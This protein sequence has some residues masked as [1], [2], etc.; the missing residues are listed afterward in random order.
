MQHEA[1]YLMDFGRVYVGSYFYPCLRVPR[2][3]FLTKVAIC[4]ILGV[5]MWGGISTP[6]RVRINEC[7]MKHIFWE[8]LCTGLFLSPCG[9][10]LT[11]VSQNSPFDG[12]K[13]VY[14]RGYFY[15]TA[16]AN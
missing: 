2:D 15:P 11:T 5:L 10:L 4:W 6:L 16:G 9:C 13:R 7:I 3:E 1:R 12:F 8:T 14:V